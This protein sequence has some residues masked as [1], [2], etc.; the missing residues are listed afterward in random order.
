M[1]AS[2]TQLV[3]SED[4]LLWQQVALQGISRHQL[5]PPVQ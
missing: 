1:N 4:A 3:E 2:D 5:H